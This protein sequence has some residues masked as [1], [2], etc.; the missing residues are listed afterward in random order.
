MTSIQPTRQ[1]GWAAATL[2]LVAGVAAQSLCAQS[3]ETKLDTL[4]VS[5]SRTPQDLASTPNSV[6]VLDLEGLQLSQVT[7]LRQA[8]AQTPGL[9]IINTGAS[10][11]QTSVF[12]RGAASYQTLFVVD[13]VRMNDRSAGYQN[14]FGAA[15]LTGLDRLEIL[16][17]PQ[18]TLYGSSAVGGVILLETARG[19]GKPTGIIS[20]DAGN[21]GSAGASASVKGGI[22]NFGYSASLGRSVTANDRDYNHSKLWDYSTRLEFQATQ[23]VLVG[24]TFRGQQGEYEEPDSTLTAWPSP[25]FVESKNHLVTA[26]AQVQPV[27][28]FSSRLTTAW[29]KREYGYTT[30]YGLSSQNNVRKIADWQNTWTPLKELELVGGFNRELSTYDIGSSSGGVNRT[31]DNLSAAYFSA[32]AKPVAGLS[33]NAGLR[34]DDYASFG[35][36]TTWRSGAAYRFSTGTKI[37]ATYGTSFTAPGSD[38]RYGVPSWGMVGNPDL[39]PEKSRGWEVGVDQ[40]V[41]G[42]KSIVGVTYFENRFRNIFEWK[43]IDYTTYAGQTVNRARARS[44]GTEVSFQVKPINGISGH[45]AYTYLDTSDDDTGVRLNR[46]PRHT[47]DAEVRYQATKAW[48]VGTGVRFVAD[49]FDGYLS[50]GKINPIEDYTSVRVFTS[51]DVSANLRLKLRVENLL[52]EKY[53]EVRGYP[54]LPLSFRS[55]VEWRF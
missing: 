26:Y 53:A 30:A 12:F 42:G 44:S 28:E 17:G 32:A 27:T 47:T 29:H 3:T 22:Q 18:G 13:G 37:R 51:Y 6:T 25:G 23:K 39:K 34:H 16:R 33:L 43:T 19:C 4:V 45:L 20:V 2:A 8:V 52:D 48:V 41:F 24:A 11:G 31:K 38:D 55:S 10:G 15:G 46:R 21:L 7:D 35:G 40:E 54:S 9:T 1:T 49:R 14:F 36:A 50:S 5:A